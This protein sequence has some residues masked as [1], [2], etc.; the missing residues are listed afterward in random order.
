[1]PKQLPFYIISP[2]EGYTLQV[3]S[4]KKKKNTFGNFI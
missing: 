2:A 4:V 3:S 1:M